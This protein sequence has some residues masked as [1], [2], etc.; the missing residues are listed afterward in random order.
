VTDAWLFEPV[1]PDAYGLGVG[2]DGLGRPV[3]PELLEP[4]EMLP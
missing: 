3:T 4:G 2:S 1:T